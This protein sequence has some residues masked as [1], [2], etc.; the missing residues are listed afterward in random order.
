MRK[1]QCFFIVLT[2]LLLITGG[3]RRQVRVYPEFEPETVLRAGYVIQVGAFSV[4]DNAVRLT[5][6]LMQRGLDPY[7]FRHESGLYKVRFG[8]FSTRKAA[9]DTAVDLFNKTIIPDYYI[10]GPEEHPVTR[11]EIYGS[12]YL[13][14]SIV[15]TAERFL[16]VK[17][18]WG[19][20]SREE[21]FDCSGLTMVVYRLNGLCLPRNSRLQYNAGK[22]VEFT[23]LK[24]G[25]LVFFAAVPSAARVSHVGIY[26]GNG[27]FIHAPG[28]DSRIRR[29][30]LWS[31]FY[32]ERFIGAKNYIQVDGIRRE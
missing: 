28:A 16:G 11:A 12:D 31:P 27:G 2:G 18:S 19:G 32:R 20:V 25:D 17:Y 21:G 4:L 9:R 30:W 10:V 5:E 24:K 15:E 13:R 7:Y 22:T 14:D 23:A 3:C 6:T 26:T 8:D 1:H 29:D